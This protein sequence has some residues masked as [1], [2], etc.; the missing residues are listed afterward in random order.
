[1]GRERALRL[2]DFSYPLLRGDAFESEDRVVRRLPLGGIFLPLAVVST[3]HREY[4]METVRGDAREIREKIALEAQEKA[5]EL[6]P[7]GC[8]MIDKWID[9]S[10]IEGEIIRARVVLEVERN[11]AVARKAYTSGGD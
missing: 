10:M 8:V 4:E 2:M 3:E 7:D 1:V 6:L 9:Y 5:L 11:I